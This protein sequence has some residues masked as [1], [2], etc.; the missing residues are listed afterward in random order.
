MYCNASHRAQTAE[1]TTSVLLG[2]EENGLIGETLKGRLLKG[3]FD[4]RMHI[5]LLVPLPFPIQPP[6]PLP[7]SH[8]FP[9]ENHPHC[10]LNPAPNPPRDTNRNSHP[11]AEI[12]SGKNYLLVSARLRIAWLQKIHGKVTWLSKLVTRQTRNVGAIANWESRYIC[13]LAI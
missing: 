9:Q 10:P 12:T 2:M 7:L 1:T 4:K 3:S 8:I 11:F 5:D 6:P 13:T